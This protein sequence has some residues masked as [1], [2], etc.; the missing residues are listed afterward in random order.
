MTL[1]RDDG[2]MILDNSP[3]PSF[4]QLPLSIFCLKLKAALS[5]IRPMPKD[6]R[7]QLLLEIPK[8]SDPLVLKADPPKECRLVRFLVPTAR[9]SGS[10]ERKG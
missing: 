7:F 6:F 3:K 9:I 10:D 1:L 2:N 4:W 5:L 8:E